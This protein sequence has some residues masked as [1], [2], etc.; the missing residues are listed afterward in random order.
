MRSAVVYYS[1]TGATAAV[2][3]SLAT[4][5]DADVLE[6]TC[7]RYRSGWFR[8]LLAGYDSVRGK[9]PSIGLKK[10]TPLDSDGPDTG[11]L[12]GYDLVVLAAPIWTSYPAL[13]LRAFL[14]GAPSLPDRVALLLTSG[15]HSP[16]LKAV[17]MVN[18]LLAVDVEEW[19]CIQHDDALRSGAA[20]RVGQ[21]AKRL[22]ARDPAAANRVDT[23]APGP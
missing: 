5:L 12:G 16:P 22:M 2:A 21:L 23:L 4:A 9:L 17:Q 13:P 10:H 8:Y 1:R 14:D 18:R 20:D 3:W 19:L 7:P 11:E 15:G 6:I